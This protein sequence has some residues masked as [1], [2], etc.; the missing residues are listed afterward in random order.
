MPV[1]LRSRVPA[2]ITS[3]IRD[4]RSVLA[5]CS[6]STQEMASEMFDLP[7]PFGPMMAATPSPWNFSSVRS[8]KDLNPRI[9]SFFSLSNFNSLSYDWRIALDLTGYQ[10]GSPPQLLR[11]NLKRLVGTP[12]RSR[13]CKGEISLGSSTKTPYTVCLFPQPRYTA[14]AMQ[15][16]AVKMAW[17]KE[18]RENRESAITLAQANVGSKNG[19]SRAVELVLSAQLLKK[20]TN[21]FNPPIE[22]G[23]MKLLIG[24]V[25]IVIGQAKA[26]HH[27]RNLQH[28]LK[29]RNDG[30]R[31][32]RSNKHGVLVKHFVHGLGSG[33]DVLVVRAHHAGRSLAPDLDLGFDPLGR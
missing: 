27:A 18:G 25:K 16:V 2:K 29:I 5:D 14:H 7:Q 1:G 30:N 9:C 19:I 31:T 6:P 28:I 3:S 10:L 15:Q 32:T 12:T 22:V 17:E 20:Q 11:R 24:R 23:N 33:L 26:H 4:P 21:R 8:Q 13:Y